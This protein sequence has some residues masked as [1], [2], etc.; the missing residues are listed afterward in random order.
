M[1]L[2]LQNIFTPEVNE[3]IQIIDER[4]SLNVV[5]KQDLVSS[6]NFVNFN[7]GQVAWIDFQMQK[8]EYMNEDASYSLKVS[9]NVFLF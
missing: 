4:K 9:N 6:L 2:A 5:L 1:N 3:T 7:Q 8:S